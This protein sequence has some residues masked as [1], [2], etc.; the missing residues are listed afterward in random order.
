MSAPRFVFLSETD[1]AIG[2]HKDKLLSITRFIPS[3]RGKL[4][5]QI[6][7]GIEFDESVDDAVLQTLRSYVY[8][9]LAER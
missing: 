2:A 7:Y 5:E 3:G 6:R 9:H 8:E 1:L 4:A